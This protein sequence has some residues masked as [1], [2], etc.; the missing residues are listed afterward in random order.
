MLLDQPI[1]V[2]QEVVVVALEHRD[3]E[4]EDQES[5]DEETTNQEEETNHQ[6]EE[7]SD[8]MNSLANNILPV[9]VHTFYFRAH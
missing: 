1:A 8:W 6:I 2:E 9:P 3:Q 7:D 4:E 5:K